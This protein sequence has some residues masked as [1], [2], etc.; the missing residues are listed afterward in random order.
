MNNE[1]GNVL[2]FSWNLSSDILVRCSSHPR[3][4]TSEDK[5]LLKVEENIT[6]FIVYRFNRE[7]SQHGQCS[8]LFVDPT[9]SLCV[10]CS[11][12]SL[13]HKLTRPSQFFNVHTGR[14]GIYTR[15]K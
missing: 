13:H 12:S 10:Q 3:G 9:L 11:M 1:N 14:A 2:N 15:L 8:V 5:L 6:I 7:M 4:K